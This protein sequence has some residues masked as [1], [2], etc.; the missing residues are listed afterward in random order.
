MKQLENSMIWGDYYEQ[1]YGPTEATCHFC[2]NIDALENMTE[3]YLGVACEGCSTHCAICD[4]WLC[5]DPQVVVNGQ[6]AHRT[7]A[8]DE[9]WLDEEKKQAAYD[10]YV[11]WQIEDR[12]ENR[13]TA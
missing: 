11:D 3:F 2:G 9:G 10:A 13:R 1:C 4:D 5:E 7:C 12:K 6:C 8:E